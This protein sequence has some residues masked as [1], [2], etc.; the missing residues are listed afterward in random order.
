MLFCLLANHFDT[1][2]PHWTV[3]AGLFLNFF[4]KMTRNS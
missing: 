3:K 4:L 2:Y 1:L